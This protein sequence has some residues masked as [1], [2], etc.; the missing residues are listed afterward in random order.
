M[1]SNFLVIDASSRYLTVAAQKGVKSVVRHIPDCA[2]QHSVILMEEV[3]RAFAEADLTPA[4]C[5][6]FGAVTGPGSF[7]GIR[8]GI[9]T[10]KG[11]ALGAN[12]PL[13]G[14]T[15]F[16]LFAY[17]ID[18]DNFCVVIDAAHSHFY[19]QGFGKTAFPPAYLSLDEIKALGC[20]LFGFEDLPFPYYTK[21]N[22]KDC[23][24][25]AVLKSLKA[26][27]ALSEEI[28]ALY[29]RKSQAEEGRK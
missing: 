20:P 12:K 27:D 5:D 24:L 19:A 13:M 1:N 15:A 28:S 23:L 9:S 14:L 8:I 16:R 3:E 11:L 6:F 22:P 25:P 10:A 17:N 2:M 29:V 7:T 4:E 26:P 21:L 18:S